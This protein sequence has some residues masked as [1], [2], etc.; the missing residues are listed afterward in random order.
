[1]PTLDDK[2]RAENTHGSNTDTRLGGTV[3]GTQAGEDNGTG[4]THGTE[5]GL[6]Y[7]SIVCFEC[8]AAGAGGRETEVVVTS[9]G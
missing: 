2:V 3:R 1:M 7:V 5:E 6:D 9:T 8:N 4:A